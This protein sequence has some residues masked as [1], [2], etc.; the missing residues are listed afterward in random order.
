VTAEVETKPVPVIVRVCAA[1]PA[2]TD[3]GERLVMAGAGFCEVEELEPQPAIRISDAERQ[4]IQIAEDV[5][6]MTSS[7]PQPAF[8]FWD[9]VG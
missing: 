3:D 9:R 1:A 6:V 4:K 5:L 8:P 2:L 7:R